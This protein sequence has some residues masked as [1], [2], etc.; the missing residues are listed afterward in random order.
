MYIKFDNRR[1]RR[2][3]LTGDIAIF[4]DYGCYYKGEVKDVSYNG[5]RVDFP[6]INSRS[7]FWPNF[8]VF[9]SATI[10]RVRKFRILICTD[11]A[12]HNDIK[13]G[14]PEET[15]KS[16]LVSA[17]PRWMKKEENRLQIGFKIPESS[18]SWQYFVHQKLEKEEF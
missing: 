18:V 3:N 11:T 13:A 16:F 4:M 14:L 10:W 9:F 1:F 2:V 12:Q 15:K 8:S 7:I 5:F 17:Y 6:S